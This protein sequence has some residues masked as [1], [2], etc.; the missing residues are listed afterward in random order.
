MA[1]PD[2]NPIAPT[3]VVAIDGPS[4]AGK[5]TIARRLAE[6][7]GY[8]FL[9]TG[10]MYRAVT[11]HFLARGVAPDGAGV[12]AG[13]GQRGMRDA[14]AH[15]DLLLEDGRV[16]LNGQDVTKH[17]RTREVESRVSAVSALS[18]V[19]ERM[20]ELQREV[21]RRGPI[22]AEGRDM[23]SVVFPRARWKV[24]LDAAPKERA[25][26]R[27]DDF[28]RQGREVSQQGVLEEILARDLHDSTRAD[29]PLQ[30]SPDALYVD[31]TD[32]TAD[33]VIALLLEHVRNAQRGAL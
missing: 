13:V 3:E 22:V 30:R 17:L 8:G 25:R 31:S 20:A 23:G 27:C 9:D 4:G 21:A 16:W 7:L 1:A 10:A 18:F 32:M 12:D 24:Y 5:S 2:S 11:W 26:R 14:L 6:E 29:A 28:A 33:G 19:R 15:A